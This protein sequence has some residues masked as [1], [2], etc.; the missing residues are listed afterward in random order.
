MR[1]EGPASLTFGAFRP[2][3]GRL[4]QELKNGTPLEKN[5]IAFNDVEPAFPIGTIE[6]ST[7]NMCNP[8]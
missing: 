7:Q 4:N 8:I 5:R 1:V 6:T 2:P 3:R